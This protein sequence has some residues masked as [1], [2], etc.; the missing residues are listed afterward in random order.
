[1]GAKLERGL[2]LGADTTVV[3]DE[4]LLGQPTDDD[5]A[6]RMLRLLSSKWHA[7]RILNAD[8]SFFKPLEHTA[9]TVVLDQKQKLF[10]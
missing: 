1:M 7:N 6:R 10:F 5:D 4:H 9:K 3:V 8:E 2:V